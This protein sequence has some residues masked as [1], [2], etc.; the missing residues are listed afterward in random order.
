MGTDRPTPTALA[1][2]AFMERIG[3]GTCQRIIRNRAVMGGWVGAR[4]AGM[5]DTKVSDAISEAAL[6]AVK[7]LFRA[8][9]A[10]CD[11]EEAPEDDFHCTVCDYDGFGVYYNPAK[12]KVTGAA[13]WC[14]KCGAEY[15]RDWKRA[16]A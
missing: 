5:W 2:K 6:G 16:S 7:D 1:A 4:G 15:D 14:V 3:G 9:A 10:E 12:A 13:Y 11:E 8:W